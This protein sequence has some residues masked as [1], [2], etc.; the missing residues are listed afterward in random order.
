MSQAVKYDLFLYAH[1]SFLICQHK[2]INEVE[3]LNEDFANICDWFVDNR[4]NIKF[5]EDNTKSR[6]FAS[7]FRRKIIEKHRMW[8]YWTEQYLEKQCYLKL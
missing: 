2:D 6:V 8:G 3:Q 7:K 1:V 4:L 5:G